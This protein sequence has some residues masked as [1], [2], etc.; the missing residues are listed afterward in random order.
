MPTTLDK[1]DPNPHPPQIGKIIEKIKRSG[2]D[3]LTS[4][5]RTMVVEIFRQAAITNNKQLLMVKHDIQRAHLAYCW[6][7]TQST[8]EHK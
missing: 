8:N 2:S 7:L 4:M 1:P 5:E 3:A 6:R